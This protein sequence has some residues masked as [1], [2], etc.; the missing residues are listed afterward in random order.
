MAMLKLEDVTHW[1]IPVNNLEQAEEFYREVLGMEHKGRIHHG[2]MSCFA[3]GGNSIILCQRQE[4]VFRTVEQDNH[5]HHAFTVS[6][7]TFDEACKLFHQIGVPVEQPIEHLERGFFP[8]RHLYFLDPS[9]NR[10]ELRDP[11]WQPGMPR[12]SF[13]EIVQS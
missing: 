6:P 2:T 10:L 4:P 13:A 12:R 3:L 7:K 9:G 11:S 8:G 5:L 1:S